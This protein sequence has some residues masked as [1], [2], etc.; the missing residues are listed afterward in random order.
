MRWQDKRRSSNIEDRRQSGG[1]ARKAG[2]IGGVGLIVVLAIGY[3]AGIDVTPLL[4]GQG[5]GGFAATSSA[6]I[7]PTDQKAGDFAAA[8]FV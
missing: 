7:T 1:G 2:G 5:Q 6:E 4:Q 8:S 3:F